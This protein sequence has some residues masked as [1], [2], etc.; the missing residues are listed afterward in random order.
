MIVTLRKV[1][2]GLWKAV[3]KKR[4]IKKHNITKGP[5][6]SLGIMLH[7]QWSKIKL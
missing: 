3:V 1:I 4:K 6:A 2:Y 5:P 7:W